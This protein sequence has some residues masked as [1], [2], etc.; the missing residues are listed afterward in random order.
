LTPFLQKEK[1]ETLHKGKIENE[2]AVLKRFVC[3]NCLE[4]L[5]VNTASDPLIRCGSFI[6]E[7]LVS[8]LV[9]QFYDIEMA[10]GKQK[11]QTPPQTSGIMSWAWKSVFPNASSTSSTFTSPITEVYLITE[12]LDGSM[13]KHF[14]RMQKQAKDQNHKIIYNIE[15]YL[16][17]A[18]A[19]VIT[20][21]AIFQENKFVTFSSE[22]PILDLLSK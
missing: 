8:V 16:H 12:L 15:V 11:K 7:I 3:E 22:F 19:Q 14:D 9:S 21:L 4:N 5:D 20:S 2:V 6:Q 18:I 1:A 13:D 17:N 10:I